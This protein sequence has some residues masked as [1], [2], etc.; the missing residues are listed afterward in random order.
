MWHRPRMHVEV[1]SP[2]HHWLF[3]FLFVCVS[4]FIVYS[5]DSLKD[6]P[7]AI[8]IVVLYCV[9]VRICG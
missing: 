6:G 4:I 1:S 7:R 8:Y 9:C 3:L 2:Q 5:P